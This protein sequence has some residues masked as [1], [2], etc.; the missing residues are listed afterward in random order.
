MT[1]GQSRSEHFSGGPDESRLPEV[2]DTVT[3]APFC[4]STEVKNKAAALGEKV[5]A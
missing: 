2:P 5:R 1:P 4:D 3:D